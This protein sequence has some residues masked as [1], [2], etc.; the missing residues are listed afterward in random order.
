MEARAI[1]ADY[2]AAVQ[3]K[4]DELKKLERNLTNFIRRCDTACVGGPGPDCIILHDMAEP[5]NGSGRSRVRE[6]RT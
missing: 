4:L 2:L 1:A 6:K 5:A 3:D